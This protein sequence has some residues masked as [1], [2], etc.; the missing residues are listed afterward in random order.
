LEEND[1]ST[2]QFRVN[3]GVAHLILNQ[4]P[5]NKMTLA[6]F[7]EFN[8]I[9]DQIQDN[10]AIKALV[11]SG[12]GRHFSSGADLPALL[13]EIQKQSEVDTVGKL[14][15]I[16]D[17][18]RANYQ[19]I[20][21]LEAMN[22]PVI[23][24]IRGVCLGSALELALFCHF[25]FCG[26]DTV[27]GLPETSFNLIPGLGGI[28]K[29]TSL[30]GKANALEFILRGKTFSAADALKIHIVDRIFPKRQVVDITLGFIR[31][32]MDDYRKEKSGMYLKKFLPV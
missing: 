26:E 16:P 3:E 20:L 27:F 29:M 8:R 19:S 22:I 4:P 7:S 28:R 24:A 11:I 21:K 1:R 17:F 13:A 15:F 14:S 18:M 6:F 30:A 5:S 31:K 10:P 2:I 23:S 25:R 9:I 32:I 12:N